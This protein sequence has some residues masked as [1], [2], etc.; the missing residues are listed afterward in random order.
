MDPETLTM[1]TTV[2]H[3]LKEQK[4]NGKST[5]AILDRLRAVVKGVWADNKKSTTA[6]TSK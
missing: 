2:R 1:L 5:D 6:A 3:Y 4:R